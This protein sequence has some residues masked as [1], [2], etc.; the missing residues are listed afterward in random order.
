MPPLQ[1]SLCFSS[2]YVC[3]HAFSHVSRSLLESEI[4][5]ILVVDLQ[6]LRVEFHHT[7]YHALGCKV[8]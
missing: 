6:Y 5:E 2:R 7:Q 3:G 4:L 8:F 1:F